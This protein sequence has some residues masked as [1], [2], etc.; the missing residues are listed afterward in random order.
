MSQSD[1]GIMSEMCN[2]HEIDKTL[3]AEYL[4]K[5]K[6]LDSLNRKGQ[7]IHFLF[8]YNTLK[9]EYL[10]ENVYE[11]TGK[12]KSYFSGSG[13]SFLK[14][15]F[16]EKDIPFIAN[17]IPKSF[18]QVRNNYAPEEIENL[19]FQIFT[20]LS[21]DLCGGRNKLFQYKVVEFDEFKKPLLCFGWITEV[22][23]ATVPQ[24]I[25]IAVNC[26]KDGNSQIVFQQKFNYND[27]SLSNR[28]IQIVRLLVQG[29]TSQ[30]VA[31]D[32]NISVKTVNNH[33]QNILRKLG[34][35]STSEVVKYAVLHGHF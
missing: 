4:E 8:N 25:S 29:H 13:E 35:K 11:V 22:S 30:D 32:L 10:S 3:I 21:E 5:Y 18:Q 33:R 2:T 9:V 7:T 6:V 12:D 27:E 14:K 1:Y 16:R 24:Y 19:S 34:A 17:E 23:F 31:D 15:V 20:R 28:E 26:I